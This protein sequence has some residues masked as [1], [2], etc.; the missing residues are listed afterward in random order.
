MAATTPARKTTRKPTTRKTAPAKAEAPVAPPLPEGVLVLDRPGV[1]EKFAEQLE[2]REPL[3]ALGDEVYTIPKTVPTSWQMQTFYLS[4]KEG[5][6]VAVNYAMAQMLGVRGLEALK[7][8]KTLLDED[9]DK[10]C[11]IVMGKVLPLQTYV[12]KGSS[13]DGGQG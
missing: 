12:P 5:H 4:Q 6:T 10:L 11:M 8:C 2:D 1:A 7:D 9:V 3:F 13:T